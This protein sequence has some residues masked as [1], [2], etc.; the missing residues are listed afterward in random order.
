M[1]VKVEVD[2]RARHAWAFLPSSARP[3]SVWQGDVG[4]LVLI[5]ADGSGEQLHAPGYPRGGAAADPCNV[6]GG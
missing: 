6:R 5:R 4:E 1:T 3:G 2:P